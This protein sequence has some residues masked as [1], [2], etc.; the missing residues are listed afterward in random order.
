MHDC[1]WLWRLVQPCQPLSEGHIWAGRWSEDHDPGERRHMGRHPYRTGP[2]GLL[3]VGPATCQSSE[4]PHS[5]ELKSGFDWPMLQVRNLDSEVR[6]LPKVTTERI[7]TPLKPKPPGPGAQ[8]INMLY[9]QQVQWSKGQKSVMSWRA[10]SNTKEGPSVQPH[11]I[12]IG[13]EISQE[14]PGICVFMWNC[15]IFQL[16]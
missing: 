8:T 16:W 12:G 14:K 2:Q 7:R 15:P 9:V 11:K 3:S 13:R 5:R 6:W 4:Q 10:M 1:G